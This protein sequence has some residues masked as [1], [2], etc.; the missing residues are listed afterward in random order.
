MYN[1]SICAFLRKYNYR[2]QSKKTIYIF[3]QFNIGIPVNLGIFF[4][5]TEPKTNSIFF[6]FE[7]MNKYYLDDLA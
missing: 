2:H 4:F 1:G 6:V 5:S 7:S 3:K